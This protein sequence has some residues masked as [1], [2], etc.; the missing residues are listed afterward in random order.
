MDSV[1]DVFAAEG[2]VPHR[3]SNEAGFRY[4]EHSHPYHKVLVCS[5]GSITFH[6]VDRDVAL[7]PGKRLDLP[8]HT[9]HAATVGPEGVEC[10]EAAQR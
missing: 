2:L 5:S 9:R 1:T 6:L 8:P 4:A 7:S 10:W 3:W